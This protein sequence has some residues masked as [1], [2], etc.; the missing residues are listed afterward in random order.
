MNEIIKKVFIT[1]ASGGIGASICNK[2]LN[3]KP[4]L[5]VFFYL[6]GFKKLIGSLTDYY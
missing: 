2:F 4:L 3:K 5:S 6:S 1:G